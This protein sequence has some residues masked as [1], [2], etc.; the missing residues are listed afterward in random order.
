MVEIRDARIIIVDDEQTIRNLLCDILAR[1]VR[2]CEAVE[3]AN[4]ALDKLKESAFDIAV[5]DIKMPGTSGMELLTIMRETYP[6]MAVVM[7]TA[8]NEVNTAVEAMKKGALDYILK[9]FSVDDVR[10]RIDDVLKK[11]EAP[12]NV[13]AP[14]P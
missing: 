10:S 5:V 7:V 1:Q 12:K 3:N 8:V 11:R 13:S 6:A 14:F 9:P 2:V 4:Q